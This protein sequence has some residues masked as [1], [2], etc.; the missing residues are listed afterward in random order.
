MEASRE[1]VIPPLDGANHQ[2]EDRYAQQFVVE[3][4]PVKGFEN[5]VE[6]DDGRPI[7]RAERD[8]ARHAAW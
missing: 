1:P 7:E 2:I 8:L 3:L 5:R 4:R 6:R